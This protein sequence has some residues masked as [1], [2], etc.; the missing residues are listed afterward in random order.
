MVEIKLRKFGNS[1]GVILPKEV[2]SRL[3][4]GD[5]GKLF[6]IEEAGGDYR[7]TAYDPAFAKKVE[8]AEDIMNRYRST[9]RE[10][11]K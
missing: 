10:L 6:L 1:L 9:L 5:G 11:A 3:N 2:V 7:L 4:G 8:K